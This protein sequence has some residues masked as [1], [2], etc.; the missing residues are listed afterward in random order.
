MLHSAELYV[1]AGDAERNDDED[2]ANRDSF[3]MRL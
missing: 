1:T 3:D 2:A